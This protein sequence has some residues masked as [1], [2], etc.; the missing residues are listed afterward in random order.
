MSFE[1]PF[2]TVQ[3]EI[4]NSIDK[5]RTAYKTWLEYRIQSSK[6]DK[7]LKNEFDEKTLELRNQIRSLEWDIEDLEETFAMYE[8]YPKKLKLS[9]QELSVREKFISETKEELK[10]IKND[11]FD[12]KFNVKERNT[13]VNLI[14]NPISYYSLTFDGNQSGKYKRLQES[15]SEDNNNTLRKND[16]VN[17]NIEDRADL[18]PSNDLRL[19]K[20]MEQ[21]IE[22][23]NNDLNYDYNINDYSSDYTQVYQPTL[24]VIDSKYD[25]PLKR[26]ARVFRLPDQLNKQGWTF[27]GFLTLLFVFCVVPFL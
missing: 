4:V 13:I 7:D 9:E 23:E 26:V 18:I 17:I 19:A 6:E 14:N 22:E 25:S 2:I 5:T 12:A 21:M 3:N 15:T 20:E 16:D 11:V 27:V 24:N 1:D 10:L 8:S